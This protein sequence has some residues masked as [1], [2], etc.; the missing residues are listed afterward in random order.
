MAKFD[1]KELNAELKRISKVID[2]ADR[3]RFE[4]HATICCATP[5]AEWNPFQ[6]VYE[7]AKKVAIAELEIGVKHEKE[8]LAD[9]ILK[10]I[11]ELGTQNKTKEIGR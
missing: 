10:A 11:D 9:A 7:A 3:K 6:L 2:E 4:A 5:E 8:Q 1:D